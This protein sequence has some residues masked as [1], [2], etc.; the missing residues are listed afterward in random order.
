[1]F[2]FVDAVRDKKHNL[3]LVDLAG[4]AYGAF[5][6]H[7]DYGVAFE[8]SCKTDAIGAVAVKKLVVQ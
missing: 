2:H 4:G 8:A 5:S 1:M 7:F 6:D 3:I